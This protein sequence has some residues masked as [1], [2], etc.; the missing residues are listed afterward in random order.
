MQKK[1]ETIKTRIWFEEPESDN[2][3][4]AN[5]CYCSG[6]DVYG[7]L[8]GNISWIQYLYLLFKLELPT[9]QQ[10]QLLENLAVALANPGIRDH[11]VRAA[12]NAGVGGSTRASA[13]MAALAVGAG[14]LGGGREVFQ[15]MGLWKDLG[16]D[17]EPWRAVL[18]DVDHHES[19]DVW[20]PM[21]HFPG[22][23]PNGNTCPKPI[24]QALELLAENSPGKSLK[25]LLE[26]RAMLESE[27]G[28]PLAMS[29]V[30]AAALAD[31]ELS[32]EQG[33]ML[34]LMLRLPGAAAHALEQENHGWRQYPFFGSSIKPMSDEDYQSLLRSLGEEQ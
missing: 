8:L 23:D 25:W 29:G 31:V 34:Y 7:E 32:P 27:I 4:A 19:V 28:Y 14:N 24:I 10:A 16:K 17:I 6:Y 3:Y 18:G 26:N 30:A 2:P 9:P 13:L 5:A 20:V 1:H 15:A 33:E 11:S 22:F 12:M 21:E